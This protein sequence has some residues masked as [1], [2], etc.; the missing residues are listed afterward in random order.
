MC[1]SSSTPAM[2]NI[3]DINFARL[4]GLMECRIDI[5]ILIGS[6]NETTCR[7]AC[8]NKPLHIDTETF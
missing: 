6:S 7:G 4:D 8:F 5:T 3:I 1:T 2:H